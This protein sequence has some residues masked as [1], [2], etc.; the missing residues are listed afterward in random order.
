MISTN[1]GGI[2]RLFRSRKAGLGNRGVRTE[3]GLKWEEME[4]R[5]TKMDEKV[6]QNSAQETI[7]LER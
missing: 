3:R 1:G 7:R 6:K 5:I 4:Q 2:L